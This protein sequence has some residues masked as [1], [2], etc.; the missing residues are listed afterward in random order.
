MNNDNTFGD[1]YLA[2][3]NVSYYDGRRYKVDE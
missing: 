3:L 1:R 2:V